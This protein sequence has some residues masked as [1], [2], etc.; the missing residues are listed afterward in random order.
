MNSSSGFV[1]K[2]I[3]LSILLLFSFQAKADLNSYFDSPKAQNICQDSIIVQGSRSFVKLKAIYE[4]SD[5]VGYLIKERNYFQLKLV[6]TKNSTER[7]LNIDQPV[8]DVL[9]ENNFI[10]LLTDGEVYQYDLKSLDLINHY[11]IHYGASA[12]Y[13]RAYQLAKKDERFYIAYGELGVKVFDIQSLELIDLYKPILPNTGGH[14][15]LISGVQVIGNDLVMGLDN[16]TLGPGSGDRAFEGLA[17]KNLSNGKEK[18]LK[19]NQRMEAYHLP[20]IFYDAGTIYV[21]NLQLYFAQSLDKLWKRRGALK[22]ERRHFRFDPGYL[23]GRAL[24][25]NKQM[26]GCFRSRDSFN[27]ILSGSHSLR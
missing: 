27:S 12:R 20:Y 15:S 7:N 22:P 21:N 4:I 8:R 6:N 11:I 1:L 16:T 10:Y 23:I 2:N 14:R 25:K 17:L 19:I 13:T 24:I 9:Y 26:H 18:N 5:E 3:A